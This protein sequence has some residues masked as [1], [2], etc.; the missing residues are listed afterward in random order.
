MTYSDEMLMAYVDR[1]LDAATTA[2]IDAA[3]ARDTELAR[4]G[5]RQRK[6][7]DSVPAAYDPMLEEPMPKR[8]LDAASGT[9]SV[10]ATARTPRR[11]AWFEWGAMAASLALGIAIGAAFLDDR[12]RGSPDGGGDISAEQG[13]LLARGALARALTDQLASTQKPEAPV[14]IGLTFLSKGGEYC[15]TFA[16]EQS[17]TAGFACSGASGWRID[18]LAPA[19]RAGKAP[20]YRTARSELPPTVLRS[21]EERM[22]GTSLDSAAERAAQQSGWRR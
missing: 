16:L 10:A 18:V 8:L 3:F 6:L 14:R 19:E 9:A 4:R 21:I 22:Q 12:S 11:W 13:Q 7:A 17:S 5:E 1:A 2:S 20:E 15:R